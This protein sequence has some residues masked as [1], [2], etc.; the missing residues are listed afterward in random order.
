MEVI[1]DN[2]YIFFKFENESK[3]QINS[4]SQAFTYKDDT[5][6]MS[7]KGFDPKKV[8]TVNFIDKR[9]S[10]HML[11][12][13]FLYEFLKTCKQKKIQV[14]LTDRREKFDFQNKEHENLEQ[15][16]PYDYN[17]HETRA[18]KKMLKNT[19]GIIKA[20]TS[21][22]KGDII[23]AYF[24]HTKISGLVLV[25]KK[26]LANQLAQRAKDF[27]IKNVGVWHGDKKEFGDLVF[28]TIQSA[29]GLPS[30]NFDALVI[31]EVH[32]ASSK[33][34]Q[35]FLKKNE[36][37]VKFGF[38]ATPNKG[39]EY[40]F[41]TIRQFLG[42]I[43]IEIKAPE[44]M[45]NEVVARPSIY[46]VP[47]NVKP[48]MDWPRSY[49]YGIIKN[50]E[51][52]KKIVEIVEAFNEKTL[53]LIKDVKNKQGELIQKE[54][55]ELTDKKVSFI[56]GSTKK[57]IQQELEEFENGSTDVLIA[58]NILNEGIS[59]K[60]IKL[61]V[62]A[63]GGKSSKEQVQKLGRGL[64]ITEDKRKVIVVDFYD[65]GNKFTERHSNEREKTYQKE[66]FDDINH[67]GSVDEIFQ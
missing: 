61:L 59:I 64:R 16:F 55:E 32:N 2:N 5:K 29:K 11:Y 22:G 58:T 54:I 20:I 51:R 27:G 34:F 60:T 3:S 17:D 46:F 12:S 31:D 28:A 41:A 38:S 21:A 26:A 48:E 39:N 6:A 10:V 15:Y 56:H 66:G 9:K 4:I 13:G 42:P 45:Q 33:T 7:A 65:Y 18:L 53:V 24:K 35:D 47:V 50:K 43:I 63:S 30:L 44:L 19:N 37:K 8:K 62:N 57:D 40:L 36:F 14:N 23:A 49:V 67:V 52:N 25:N 1:I